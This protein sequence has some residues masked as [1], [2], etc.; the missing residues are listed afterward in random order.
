MLYKSRVNL[1][2]KR[3]VGLEKECERYN[4]RASN[5]ISGF[6]TLLSSLGYLQ[7]ISPDKIVGVID[8]D[9]VKDYRKAFIEAVKALEINP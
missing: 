4:A 3:I 6:L 1:L 9:E 5:S 7:Q 2:E 8:S